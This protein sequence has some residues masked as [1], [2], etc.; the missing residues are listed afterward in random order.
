MSFT[1]VSY[2]YIQ[3]RYTLISYNICYS[4]FSVVSVVAILPFKS[5]A[6]KIPFYGRARESDLK[7]MLRVTN[8]SCIGCGTNTVKLTITQKYSIQSF[9]SFFT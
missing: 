1:F 5:N 8:L 7:L 4:V 6:P 9:K 2:R 3:F